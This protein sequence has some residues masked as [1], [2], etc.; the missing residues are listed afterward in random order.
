VGSFDRSIYEIDTETC[1]PTRVVFRPPFKCRWVKSLERSPSTLLVQCR[2]G[3]LYK[4]SSET[5]RCLAVIRQTPDALWTAVNAPD[6]NILI[7]GDGDS[8]LRV[9]PCGVESASRAPVFAASRVPFD[10]TSGSYTKRMVLHQPT[11]RLVLGRTDGNVVTLGPSGAKRL[12]N[13]GSAVRDLDVSRERN[14]AFGAC[15][16]GRVF[17]LDLDTGETLREFTSPANQPFWALT[18]NP[19]QNVLAVGERGGEM[20]VLDADDFSVLMSGIATSRMK[21]MKWVDA[22]TLLFN[23]QDEVHRFNIKTGLREQ[24]TAPAG[25]TIEDFI[26]DAERRYLV[27]ISYTCNLLLCDLDT[28]EL[29][30]E[31]PDQMDYSKGLIWIDPHRRFDAY[32]LDFLTFGRSGCA[33]HFR[34][35]DEKILALGPV[36]ERSSV[37]D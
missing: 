1:M 7:T 21:R 31:V 37:A 32:P 12:A 26:W 14:E 13:V 10:V 24:L 16:D 9:R 5:G 2:N 30:S 29:L 15:E 8:L 22:D 11:G 35:H 23:K 19:Q 17:K 4:A 28:G 33:H 3:A 6:G 20:F 34:I 36:T 27:M 18:Y 25:N